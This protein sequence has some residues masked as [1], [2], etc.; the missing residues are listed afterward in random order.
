MFYVINIV[1]K[2]Q[3]FQF[4]DRKVQKKNQIRRKRVQFKANLFHGSVQLI[5]SEKIGTINIQGKLKIA[6][7]LNKV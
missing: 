3:P 4:Y 7:W 5:Y 6:E 2:W 1:S